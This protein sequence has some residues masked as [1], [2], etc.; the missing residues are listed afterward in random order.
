M[1]E[2]GDLLG[3]HLGDRAAA[4]VDGRLDPAQEE[5]AWHHV[6]HCPGCRE[7]VEQ[8]ASAKRTLASLGDAPGAPPPASWLQP[9]AL[10]AWAQVAELERGARRRTT[11]LGVAGVLGGGALTA[12]LA[13]AVVVGGGA[14]APPARPLPADVA[15]GVP[16]AHQPSEPGGPSGAVRAT[17]TWTGTP[18]GSETSRAVRTD[19]TD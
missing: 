14:S 9:E 10:A 16:A 18:T 15:R 8:Q 5:R 17:P 1:S 13:L 6:L 3:G 7:A 11:R 4:L 2:L 19:R 12:S